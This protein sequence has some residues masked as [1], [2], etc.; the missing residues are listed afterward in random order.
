MAD[1]TKVTIAAW[2]KE[3]AALEHH[4]TPD[5]PCPVSISFTETPA[6]V[7]VATDPKQPL[8]VD[9][10]MRISAREPIPLCI[11]LCEPICARSDYTIGINV[12]DNPFASIHVRGTTRFEACRD[13]PTTER[14]CVSFDN[15]KA[16]TVFPSS[17]EQQGLKFSP[18]G[19]ELRAATFGEPAGRTKLGFANAGLRVDFGQPVEDVLLTLSN[20]ASP[21]LKIAAFSGG[22]LVTEFTVSISNTF[23]EV[24]ISQSGITSLTVSGGSNEATLVEVC[25]RPA[26]HG[27]LISAG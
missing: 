19:G 2:P 6:H 8:A 20:Y 18:L 12:F 10:D 3:P 16:G 25:Y 4:F 14:Q 5:E 21:E 27:P 13:T 22:T 9:M 15:I 1:D 26:S 7:V 11:T 23:K 24:A 17:F